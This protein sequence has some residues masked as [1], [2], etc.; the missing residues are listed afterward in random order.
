LNTKVDVVVIGA[1]TDGLAAAAVLARGGKQ[2]LVVE[3]SDEVGGTG[4]LRQFAHGFTSSLSVFDSGWIS[5]MVARETGLR[6]PAYSTAGDSVPIL[7][8]GSEEFFTLSPNSAESAAS[9]A[10]FS[11]EDARRWPGFIAFLRPLIATLESLYQL[12]APRPDESRTREL[13]PLLRT[14]LQLRRSGPDSIIDILRT[15][16]LSVSDLLDEWF[17]YEPLKAALASGGL[18]G[19]RQGPRSGGTAFVMLHNLTGTTNGSVK[20]RAFAD[21]PNAAVAALRNAAESYGARVITGAAV[22]SIDVSDYAVSGV[23]LENGSGISCAAVISTAGPGITLLDLVD[24]VWLDPEVRLAVRNVRARD[25]FAIVN[26][27]LNGLPA[28]VA[29]GGAAA[30]VF[31]LCGTMT[32]ME[33]AYDA[34]KYEDFA[35]QPHAELIFPSHLWPNLCKLGSHVATAR[36]HFVSDAASEADIA[37]SCDRAIENVFPGFLALVQHRDVQT[38]NDIAVEYMAGGSSLSQGELGLDQILFMRPLP[39][40]SR[41][42]SPIDGLFLASAG[43][44]PGP[45]VLGAAGVLAARQVLAG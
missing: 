30:G 16:P 9:L 2:V 5:P 33:R 34:C 7:V 27:A 3:R 28:R 6:L 19:V 18:K 24:P 35:E 17:S 14:A 37:S 20:R 32:E 40:Y 39:E 25:S 44:H 26:Y 11:V 13:L 36:L 29:Q 1:G 4:R 8:P 23:T 12:P 22:R 10:H 38:P 21:G 15:L 42:N 43:N 41:Y 45:G 31:T